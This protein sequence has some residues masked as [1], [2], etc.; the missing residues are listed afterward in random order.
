[1][2][3]HEDQIYLMYYYLRHN[4]RAIQKAFYGGQ[5]DI[6]RDLIAD[7]LGSEFEITDKAVVDD[8]LEIFTEEDLTN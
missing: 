5:F 4:F 2:L 6:L 1:M 3:K 7:H 8:I